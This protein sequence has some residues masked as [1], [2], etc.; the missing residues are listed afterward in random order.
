MIAGRQDV[1]G[2]AFDCVHETAVVNAV[3]SG[4]WPQRCDETLV[5][6]ADTCA[7]CAEIASV[8]TL[9]R[10]D[11]EHARIEAHVPAAGQVWWRAAVRARLE[12][13]HAATKP[14]TWMHGITAAVVLG[15]FLAGL[16]ALWPRLSAVLGKAVSV[17]PELLPGTEVTTAIADGLRLSVL[18]GVVAALF[19]IVAPLA[20]Y[21]ALSDD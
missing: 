15:A 13:T 14:M 7:T 9:L 10:E 18:A 2:S 20:I 6:H 3:L 17:M 5:A 21:F 19:M 1:G 12:S 16:T 8:A 11:V 4:S